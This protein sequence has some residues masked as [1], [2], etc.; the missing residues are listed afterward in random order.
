MPSASRFQSYDFA[1]QKFSGPTCRNGHPSRTLEIVVE[2]CMAGGL[3]DG[4]ALAVDTSLIAA[5]AKKQRAVRWPEDRQPLAEGL[6]IEM[7]VCR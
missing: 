4:A 3:V 6:N 5:D 7:F 1:E 2:R